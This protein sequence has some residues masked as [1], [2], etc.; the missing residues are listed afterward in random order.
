MKKI[1]SFTLVFML[2][3]SGMVFAQNLSDTQSEQYENKQYVYDLTNSGVL[4]QMTVMNL[5]EKAVS[6]Y[7]NHNVEFY[8]QVVGLGSEN[9]MREGL[10]SLVKQFNPNTL[11]QKAVVLFV[12]DNNSGEYSLFIDNKLKEQLNYYMIYNFVS[13]LE[14]DLN[15]NNLDQSLNTNVGRVMDYFVLATKATVIVPQ[16]EINY[17]KAESIPEIEFYNLEQVYDETQFAN[18]NMEEEINEPQVEEEKN[19]GFVSYV[20]IGM[21]VVL[22]IALLFLIIWFIKRK[23]AEEEDEFIYEEVEEIEDDEEYLD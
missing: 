18:E 20:I 16:F 13:D 1:L 8:T 12:Y 14:E 7:N 9:S 2:I 15:Y 23:R 10:S 19:S 3:F 4:S 17:E 6:Y 11:N 22:L 5:Q 21:I